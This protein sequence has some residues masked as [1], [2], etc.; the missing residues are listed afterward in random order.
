MIFDLISSFLWTQSHISKVRVDFGSLQDECHILATYRGV[1][2]TVEAVQ[3]KFAG[4]AFD[5]ICEQLPEVN[6]LA[7]KE[8]IYTIK[9]GGKTVLNSSAS[10][11]QDTFRYL[12]M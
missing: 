6:D 8:V 7:L 4:C 10:L 12:V 11:N 2:V 1:W 9:S 3:A 5:S